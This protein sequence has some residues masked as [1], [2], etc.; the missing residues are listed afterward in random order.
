M[1]I[2]TDQ[3]FCTC[4]HCHLSHVAGGI[5]VPAAGGKLQVFAVFGCQCGF[6]LCQQ[7]GMCQDVHKG[8]IQCCQVG[9]PGYRLLNGFTMYHDQHSSQ[10]SGGL[11]HAVE[12]V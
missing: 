9:A 1:G 4:L 8:T 6:I 2:R 3:H 7:A 11:C 12:C 10:F 5:P